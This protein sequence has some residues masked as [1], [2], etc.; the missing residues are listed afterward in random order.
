LESYAD[1]QLVLKNARRA[2]D[3]LGSTE[4]KLEPYPEFVPPPGSS[5][6]ERKIT[7]EC[8]TEEVRSFNR[9]YLLAHTG[10]NV[11]LALQELGVAQVKGPHGLPYEQ[12][13]RFIQFGRVALLNVWTPSRLRELLEMRRALRV[14]PKPIKQ[15]LSAFL[16]K[17]SAR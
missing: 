8:N 12:Q 3:L 14:L 9:G 1:V 2:I 7:P 15:D 11:F 6:R 4:L 16:S 5:L 10:F 13:R 17:R